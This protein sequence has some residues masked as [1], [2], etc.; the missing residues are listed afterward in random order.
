MVAGAGACILSLGRSCTGTFAKL[1]GP[2]SLT[3]KL[4]RQYGKFTLVF[5]ASVCLGIFLWSSL[6]HMLKSTSTEPVIHPVG[7]TVSGPFTIQVAAYLKQSH[8]DRYLGKLK[9]RGLKAHIKKTRGGGKI[10]YLIRVSHF[11]TKQEA[12]AYGR[13]LKSQGKIEDF[14]V[15]NS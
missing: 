6:A 10:W 11:K 13:K 4:F 3:G 14:F 5:V 15:S 7:N 9:D 8:A 1:T 2:A 12:A